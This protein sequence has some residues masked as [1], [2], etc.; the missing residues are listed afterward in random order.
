MGRWLRAKA[1]RVRDLAHH[2]L[3][4]FRE[5]YDM[6]AVTLAAF[7][8]ERIEPRVAVEG[9]ELDAVLGFVEAGLGV[10]VV[11]SMVVEGRPR[12]RRVPFVSPGLSRTIAFARR[13]DVDRP[14]RPTPSARSCS[15]ISPTPRGPER[16]RVASSLLEG[17]GRRRG[18][19][20][21]SA[22]SRHAPDDAASRSAA[23]ADARDTR[24]PAGGLSRR[25]RDAP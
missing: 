22:V 20:P 12:L 21:T 19:Q 15:S 10:A 16:S 13:R 1:L 7:R 2:P 6:R 8:R 24:H 25:A 3:V 23:I 4:M 11:P 14:R 18:C 5:G 17:L 9:G